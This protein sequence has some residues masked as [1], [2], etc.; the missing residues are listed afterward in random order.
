[1]EVFESMNVTLSQVIAREIGIFLIAILLWVLGRHSNRHD[2]RAD[3]EIYL[4]KF[5]GGILG[6][7]PNPYTI[8]GL[9]FQTLALITVI[10]LNLPLFNIVTI[11]AAMRIY[12][13]LFLILGIFAGLI[14]FLNREPRSDK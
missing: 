10:V 12:I 11:H 13:V 9:A 2:L 7:S 14:R 8:S 6:Q 5:I 4:P 3:E 1:M